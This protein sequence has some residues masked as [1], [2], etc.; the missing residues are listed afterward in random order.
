[1]FFDPATGKFH[2]TPED[3][4]EIDPLLLKALRD[5]AS[6]TPEENREVSLRSLSFLGDY[7]EKKQL[8]HLA[9]SAKASPQPAEP[10]GPGEV[11]SEQI[12]DLL[13]GKIALR[14][15]GLARRKD[16]RDLNPAVL[17]AEARRRSLAQDRRRAKAAAKKKAAATKKKK[18]AAKPKK[19]AAARPKP[20]AAKKKKSSSAKKSSSPR[21]RRRSS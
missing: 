20:A 8:Q 16:A 21:S 3:F 19:K 13:E 2:F 6:L 5:P 12:A 9:D 14:E 15:L 10:L 17:Q 11:T 4:A 7:L 1:M 18:A